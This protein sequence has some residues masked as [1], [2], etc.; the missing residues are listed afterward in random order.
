MSLLILKD[1]KRLCMCSLFS[2]FPSCDNLTMTFTATFHAETSP[3]C[4]ELLKSSPCLFPLIRAVNLGINES[5][6]HVTHS[7]SVFRRPY[8]RA[9]CASMRRGNLPCVP[10]VRVVPAFPPRSRNSYLSV[11]DRHSQED[12]L[13]RRIGGSPDIDS[14]TVA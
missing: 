10:C 3:N 5:V 13:Q 6:D 9:I 4:Q 12:A 11:R 8:G 1:K 14:F 2:I 7:M